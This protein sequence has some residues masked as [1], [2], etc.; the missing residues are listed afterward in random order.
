MKKKMAKNIRLQEMSWLDIQMAMENGYDTILV[1]FGAMEQ[2]GPH[3]PISTDTLTA[4]KL[5]ELVALNFDNVLVAPSLVV[6]SS[7]IH[8][9]FPGTFNIEENI[10]IEY[11]KEY[12]MCLVKQNFKNIFLVP[13]HGGNFHTVKEVEAYF[14]KRDYH[15]KSAYPCEDFI[16]Y[17]RSLSAELHIP[18][19]LSGTH[20]GEMETSIYMYLTGDLN[21]MNRAERGFCDN[22]DEVRAEA[23]KQGM[24]YI[25]KNGIVG[26]ATL[27]TY[28]KGKFYVDNLVNFISDNIKN[29]I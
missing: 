4:N 11:V 14:A 19:C 9:F 5:C 22:Y 6:G 24:G 10:L 8:R 1:G 25:S 15:V 29:T 3:L 12:C 7:I 20:S 2:H 23:I 28:E 27:A 17:L 26:D 13:T 18:S 21:V 16:R